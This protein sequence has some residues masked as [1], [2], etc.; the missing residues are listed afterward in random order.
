MSEK[1][2]GIENS[3]FPPQLK[4]ITQN[5]LH[6]TNQNARSEKEVKLAQSKNFFILV[7]LFVFKQ[8]AVNT[9]LTL[10]SSSHSYFF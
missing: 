8:E 2:I 4:K 3:F 6:S 10:P 5:Y 7:S 1:K 9:G